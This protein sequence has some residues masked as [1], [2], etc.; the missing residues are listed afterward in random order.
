[1]LMGMRMLLLAVVLTGCTQ[2][3][4]G[5]LTMAL[6]PDVDRPTFEAAA[7]YW[8]RCGVSIETAESATILVKVAPLNGEGG[9]VQRGGIVTVDPSNAR[10][11]FVFAHEIGHVL[12]LRHDDSGDPAV[13]AQVRW[14]V[15]EPYESDLEQL[16]ALR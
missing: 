2:V 5:P 8:K 7:D 9:G 14:P 4:T 15:G 1:M 11:V 13:M 10:D 3:T 6:A 12:G 16:A